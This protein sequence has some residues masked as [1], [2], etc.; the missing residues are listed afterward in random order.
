MLSL[1]DRVRRTISQHALLPPESRVVIGL[2]GGADSVALTVLLTEL[3]PVDV[4]TVAGLA[5]LHHGL[6]GSAA[7]EDE[8]F[9]RALADRLALPISVERRDV[10]A[11]AREGRLSVEEAGR[12]ARYRFFDRVAARAGADRVAVGHTLE[13]QAETFLLNLLRGAGPRGLAGIHPRAGLVI[14]PLLDVRHDDLRKYLS[15]RGI[16][17][18]EDESNL[19]TRMLRN[20]VRHIL[21]PFLETH[22]SPGAAAVLARNA[23]VARDD[24]VWLEHEADKAW[25]RMARS[26]DAGVD[27]DVAALAADA[28]AL[29]RRVALRA[30]EACAGGRF[31]GFEH[32]EALLALASR[33]AGSAACD[34][35]GQ[36]AERR[37]D[38]LA[39]RPRPGPARRSETTSSS[40]R[41]SLSI[42]GGAR[43]SEAGVTITAELGP[44]PVDGGLDSLC[45]ASPGHVAVVDAALLQDALTIRS[46]RPGDRFR[47]LGLAG[48]KKLQDYFV[49]CKIAREER[50]RVPLVVDAHDRIVWVAGHATSEDFRVTGPTG[51]VVILRLED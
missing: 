44:R 3:A 10:R 20:R 19:D 28:P 23:V 13:D 9:C 26:T 38:R 48:R 50:D 4:F 21:L 51:A 12:H 40:F 36:R 31:V 14:R 11:L 8:M 45:A 22:F 15:D 37:G 43:V 41:Y 5:H 39:L 30:L 27:L 25:A 32:V 17:F 1:I 29:S 49:D 18:R 42:P 16:G 6:R 2:S 34:L 33:D 7:D 35:P 46:R 24:A 47:P